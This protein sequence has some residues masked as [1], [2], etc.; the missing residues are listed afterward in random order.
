MRTCRV[1]TS[2]FP[3]TEYKADKGN[4]CCPCRL[5]KSSAEYRR[6]KKAA[7]QPPPRTTTRTQQICEAL[8]HGPLTRYELMARLGL[9]RE[10]LNVALHTLREQRKLIVTGDPPRYNN[11]PDPRRYGIAQTTPADPRQVQH[12]RKAAPEFDAEH[13]AWLKMVRAQKQAR[14]QRMECRV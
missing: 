10:Q 6:R 3:E 11:Q 8:A 1:C 2:P 13:A 7:G 12:Y 5:A 9:A 4:I 14:Q